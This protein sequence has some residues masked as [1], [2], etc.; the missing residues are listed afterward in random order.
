[1]PPFAGL[2][3]H[4]DLAARQLHPQPAGTDAAASATR[5]ADRRATPPPAK[6]CSSARAAARPATRSTAAAAIVGP[7]LSNAGR[8]RRRRCSQKIVDPN[9][10]LH[11]RAARRRRRGAPHGHGRREDAGR[12]R[13]PR[14]PPQRRHV[15]AADGRRVRPAAPARQADA[16]VGRGREPVADAGRLRDAAVGRRRSTNLVAYLRTLQRARPAQDRRARRSAGGV[17]YERLRNAESR[18]AQLAD[19]LGRL[20]GHALLAA[21]ADHAA[22][23]RAAAGRVGV[24]RCRATRCSR[25]RRSSSTA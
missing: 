12:P 25:A 19:V 5:G 20:S 2:T 16:G 3:R 24:R 6:R 15:L 13:D 14:R 9:A 18:A 22:N 7:D 21:E 1:M 10:P 8:L 4:A 17:T 23:V 11:R